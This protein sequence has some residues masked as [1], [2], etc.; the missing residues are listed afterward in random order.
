MQ[1]Q[2]SN[3]SYL[4]IARRMILF[5]PVQCWTPSWRLS[6]LWCL[7]SISLWAPWAPGRGGSAWPPTSSPS[8][9][10]PSTWTQRPSLTTATVSS[11]RVATSGERGHYDGLY[12]QILTS[13]SQGL[14]DKQVQPG[15]AQVRDAGDGGGPYLQGGVGHDHVHGGVSCTFDVL[16]QTVIKFVSAVCSILTHQNFVRRTND[17]T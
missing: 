12:Y 11:W 3:A 4:I 10:S 7:T 15:G 6:W 8:S 16:H 1:I 2:I 5:I 9:G 17:V 14:W 13:W